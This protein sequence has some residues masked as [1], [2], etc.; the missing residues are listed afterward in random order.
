MKSWFITSGLEKHRCFQIS[1]KLGP[2]A[3]DAGGK[4]RPRFRDCGAEEGDC[5]LAAGLSSAQ[6]SRETWEGHFPPST[7]GIPNLQYESVRFSIPKLSSKPD[8]LGIFY[9]DPVA[10]RKRMLSQEGTMIP[11][12]ME[13]KSLLGSSSCSSPLTHLAAH[14]SKGLLSFPRIHPHSSFAPSF[15]PG[16]LLHPPQRAFPEPQMEV[17]RPVHSLIKQLLSARRCGSCL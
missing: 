14:D 9:S 1:E 10:E 8:S 7:L 6:D 2:R 16:L 5:C 15:T 3:L 13:Q 11:R 17:D 4:V 12:H